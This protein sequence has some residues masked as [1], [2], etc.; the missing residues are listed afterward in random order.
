MYEA[1]FGFRQRPFP[2]VPDV[3]FYYAGEA[4]EQAKSNLIRAVERAEGVGLIIGQA[5]SG[6]SLLCSLLAEH[7]RHQFQIALLTS[8][9]LCSR[10]ALLQNILFELKLPYRE[11][12][13]GELRLSLIDHLEPSD[14]CP[15]G[16]LLIVDE[17]HTLPLR[18]LEEIRMITNLVRGGQPRVRLVL[19]GDPQLEE[20]LASPR[21]ASFQQRVAVRSY[22]SH[23]SQ[24]ETA[25]FVR[26]QIATAL[27]RPDQIFDDAALLAIYHATDGVPR[28]VNQLCD[29]ALVLAC[30]G[31]QRRIHS[32]GIEEAWADLQQLPAPLAKRHDRTE[33]PAVIEFGQLADDHC[34]EWQDF[35]EQF[36]SEVDHS[37]EPPRLLM[38]D[39]DQ[40][41]EHLEFAE[42]A[43]QRH[44]GREQL[45]EPAVVPRAID[46]FGGEF[47]DEEV[48]L[49]RYAAW[50]SEL[51]RRPHV[52]SS[53]GE[54]IAAA[55][56]QAVRAEPRENVENCLVDSIQEMRN[57]AQKVIAPESP[58]VESSANPLVITPQIVAGFGHWDE[59]LW[60][61]HVVPPAASGIW[62]GDDRDML[63]IE[64]G[65]ADPESLS[66]GGRVVRQEYRELF[67]Q[68]RGG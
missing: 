65:P 19:A 47:A 15:N 25:Q 54:Q 34:S 67:G 59:Q 32:A 64:D 37:N 44:E 5:G 21:L 14:R 50:D 61:A 43:E 52:R 30:A 12:E 42:S 29:H 51:R 63:V 20:R 33:R 66:S 28:L 41:W 48:V 35:E 68:L 17:A 1:F 55:L 6:K 4:F 8:A 18:L 60:T 10:R 46:P 53:D 22:L 58:A 13:E 24:G 27:G 56:R 40:E 9:R 62:P 45:V 26:Q 3:Q 7:F 11:M 2:A 36:V 31:G 23:L 49:D 16:M 57:A 39:E 38:E